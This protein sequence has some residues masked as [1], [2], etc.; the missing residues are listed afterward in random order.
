MGQQ[1]YRTITDEIR[2]LAVEQVTE[3][4]P[5]STSVAHA[6]RVVAQQFSVS[7]NSIR[8]WMRRAGVDPAAQS[9]D[10]RLADAHATIAVLTDMNRT[11][12]ENLTG[13]RPHQG[14]H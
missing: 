9:I 14:G 12:A 3:L 11:L 5:H 7:E 13:H 2:T 4:L 8:N 6:V 10:R 1:R